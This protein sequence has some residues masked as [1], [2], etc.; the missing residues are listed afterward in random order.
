MTA[1]W[2]NRWGK[3]SSICSCSC[4][5]RTTL[6]TAP[7]AATWPA[8]MVSPPTAGTTGARAGPYPPHGIELDLSTLDPYLTQ[9]DLRDRLACRY[10]GERQASLRLSMHE[11]W[12]GAP[13]R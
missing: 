5:P 9:Q 6:G 13:M 4:A 12:V 1:K 2:G 11:S 10:C 3:I 8:E 7:S